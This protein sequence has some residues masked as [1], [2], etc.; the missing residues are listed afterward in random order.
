MYPSQ[1]I[2]IDSALNNHIPF[3]VS[4]I[5]NNIFVIYMGLV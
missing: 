4:Q 2:L 3:D 5:S 1:L